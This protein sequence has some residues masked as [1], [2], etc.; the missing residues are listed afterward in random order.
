MRF[1]LWLLAIF[2]AAVGIALFATRSTGTVTLFWPPYR[3]DLSLN[4]VL[5]LL[6][7]LFVLLYLALR[8]FSALADLPSQA[9]AWRAAQRQSAMHAELR[10]AMA[11]LLSGRFA[12]AKKQALLAHQHALALPDDAASK[13]GLEVQS[14]ALLIAAESAQSLQDVPE[15]ERLVQAALE[16]PLPKSAQHFKEGVVLRSARW[17]LDEHDPST[18]LK[19]LATL[20]QGAQRRTLAL[21]LKLRALQQAKR[22]S[23]ALETARLLAK[24]GGFSEQ[25]AQSIVRSLAISSLSEA[26]DADQLTRAWGKL[27]DAERGQAEVATHAAMRLVNLS[28]GS[29]EALEL[30]ER[31]RAWLEPIWLRYPQLSES[32][33]IRVVRALEASF[34]SDGAAVDHAWLAKIETAQRQLP[35]DTRLQYLAGMACLH[36]QLWGKAQQLLSGCVAHLGDENLKRS[37]WRNL[38][39]LAEQRGDAEAAL[40]AWKKAAH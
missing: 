10:D 27:T 8:A 34:S 20:S 33:Q 21:R 11:H 3:I 39:F 12:R 29:P 25:A 26:H 5:L 4:L 14:M 36:R 9:K 35:H 6:S 1:A 24:H 19:R 32:A 7:G 23:D 16:V 37:A 22:Q 38:A 28:A 30:H 18:T 17:M 2:A 13:H 40:A 15:R 31:A